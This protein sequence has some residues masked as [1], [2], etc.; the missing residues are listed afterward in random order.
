[1]TKKRFK[2][3]VAALGLLAAFFMVLIA[4]LLAPTLASANKDAG[5][6]HHGGAPDTAPP[7]G[8]PGGGSI[9]AENWNETGHGHGH[10]S[11][12]PFC[13]DCRVY[14]CAASRDCDDAFEG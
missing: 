9:F 7:H 12:T 2:L 4:V 5:T 8:G 10:A 6:P 1:M 3:S 13:V 11:D 14:P